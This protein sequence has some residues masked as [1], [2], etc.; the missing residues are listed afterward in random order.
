M[1]EQGVR[2]AARVIDPVAFM[3]PRI[4]KKSCPPGL[5]PEQ[6]NKQI[7]DAHESRRNIAVTTA[8]AAIQA[9]QRASEQE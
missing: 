2:A 4:D 5:T 9:Y 8:R 6:A 3:E 1:S 7:W